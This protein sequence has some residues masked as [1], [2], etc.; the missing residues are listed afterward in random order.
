M[1]IGTGQSNTTIIVTWLNSHSETDCAAQLC[2]ALVYGGYSDWFLPS[3]DEINLMYANLKVFGVGG[4]AEEPDAY[5]SSSEHDAG[6]VWAQCF[7]CGGQGL[8]YKY[9]FNRVRAVRAF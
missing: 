5:W 3:K 4:F 9:Y 8:N 2:D 6:S 7:G 1:S